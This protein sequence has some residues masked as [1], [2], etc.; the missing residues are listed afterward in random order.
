MI[1]DKAFASQY[2]VHTGASESRTLFEKILHP[3]EDLVVLGRLFLISNGGTVCAHYPAGPTLAHAEGF[4][5]KLNGFAL[6]VRP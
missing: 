6:L 1:L 5:D 2:E 4:L 3:F